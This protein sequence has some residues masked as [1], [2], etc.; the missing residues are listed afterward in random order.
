MNRSKGNYGDR[1][2]DLVVLDWYDLRE[3]K[4]EKRIENDVRFLAW[5]IV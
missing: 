4:S 5:V 3:G 1:I 2:P